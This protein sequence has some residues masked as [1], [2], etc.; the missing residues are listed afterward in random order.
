MVIFL[1]LIASDIQKIL[2]TFSFDL[3]LV[4]HTLF[5][6]VDKQNKKYKFGKNK[7]KIDFTMTMVSWSVPFHRKIDIVFFNDESIL[8][9]YLLIIVV[10]V[11]LML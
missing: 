4:F 10:L 5:I 7:K 6:R 3:F 8:F 9:L 2:I 11:Q 1:L